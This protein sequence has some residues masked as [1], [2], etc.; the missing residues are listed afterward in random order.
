MSSFGFEEYS[1]SE[2]IFLFKG[3]QS[4][5]FEQQGVVQINDWYSDNEDGAGSEGR[6][7]DSTG[8]R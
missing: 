2:W 7:D 8:H 3:L 4:F 6:K 5:Q 1:Q